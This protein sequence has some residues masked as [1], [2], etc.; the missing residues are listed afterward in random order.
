MRQ[1]NEQDE[2][3]TLLKKLYLLEQ[4]VQMVDQFMAE[5]AVE[6]CKENESI[7]RIAHS[8]RTPLTAIREGMSQ[9]HEGLL[10]STTKL[11]GEY[12]GSALHELDRLR[13]IIEDYLDLSRIESGVV[14]LRKELVD[15]VSLTK[16]VA[17][18][19]QSQLLQKNLAITT[20]FSDEKLEVFVDGDRMIQV[21]TNLIGN[22]IKFTKDGAIHVSVTSAENEITCSVSD[23][24]KGISK[25]DLPEL[26]SRYKQV[27]TTKEK[28]AGTGL[29]LAISKQFVEAH[30][31]RIWAESE[32]GKGSKFMFTLPKLEASN[33]LQEAITSGLAEAMD[34]EAELSVLLFNVTNYE[35]VC[36][37]V[38]EL[39]M[40]KMIN[41]LILLIK[42][43]FRRRTD[44]A[45]PWDF[46][47]VLAVL[48]RTAKM[49]AIRI[50]ERIQELVMKRAAGKNK[51]TSLELECH[52]VSFPEDGRTQKALLHKAL[53]E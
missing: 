19:F 31:G 47:R 7:Q 33:L 30:E 50:G 1:G 10:G 29:G 41:R 25:R 52:V 3:T 15:L 45:A 36:K 39:Q 43:G 23:T 11:Q 12:L 40:N 48:P 26:F 17:R 51:T 4:E 14:K 5:C 34:Q 16:T 28:Q 37:Q 24:G 9:V 13:R 8:L 18:R 46:R 32:E 21:F 20:S 53:S 22:A 44:Q 35:D 49:D 27:E 6:R 2:R 42:N 38:G